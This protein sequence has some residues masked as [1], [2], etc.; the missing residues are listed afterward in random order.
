MKT[1]SLHTKPSVAFCALFVQATNDKTRLIP[2]AAFHAP[3]VASKG[4]SPG[5]EQAQSIIRLANSRM[6][7]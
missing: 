3:R 6:A 5:T 1:R 2:S 4:A 7:A